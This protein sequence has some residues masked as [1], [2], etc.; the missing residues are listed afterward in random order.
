MARTPFPIPAF[1]AVT[2]TIS[3]KVRRDAAEALIDRA[4]ALE[5][6]LGELRRGHPACDGL[7]ARARELRALAG[8]LV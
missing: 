2:V 5:A 7:E 3:P 1:G 6:R 8:L 4:M